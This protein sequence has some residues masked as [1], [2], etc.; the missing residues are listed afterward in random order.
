MRVIACLFTLFLAT[1]A[2]AQNLRSFVT[3]TSFPVKIL[4]VQGSSI[5]FML[6]NDSG[7]AVQMALGPEIFVGGCPGV[8]WHSD[9]GI[10]SLSPQGMT[11]LSTPSRTRDGIMPLVPP[12]SLIQA[13]LTP[14]NNATC[15]PTQEISLPLV[16]ATNTDFL[17]ISVSTFSFGPGKEAA[18]QPGG[19]TTQEEAC[20]LHPTMCAAYK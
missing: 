12:G 15:K 17:Q 4:G 7:V 13:T 16:L 5:S 2:H 1:A 10:R 9:G 3:G 6:R 18:P 20:R 19:P 11:M 14:L 8:L